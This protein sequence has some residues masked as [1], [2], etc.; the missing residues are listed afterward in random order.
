[1]TVQELIDRLNK[2]EDKEREITVFV[3]ESAT[4]KPY[5]LDTGSGNVAIG[6]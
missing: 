6:S 3:G 1:M 5:V 4:Y 2:I